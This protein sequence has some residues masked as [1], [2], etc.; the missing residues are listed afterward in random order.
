MS[1]VDIG[2]LSCST[3]TLESG[4]IHVAQTQLT[5]GGF[6]SGAGPLTI[7]AHGASRIFRGDNASRFFDIAGVVLE[8]GLV[9]DDSANGRA[10]GGCVDVQGE[11][12]LDQ[13]T[14]Q[15]C[16]VHVPNGKAL[17]GAVYASYFAHLMFSTVRNSEAIGFDAV[18]GGVYASGEVFEA[19]DSTVE[20]N[21]ATATGTGQLAY[22]RGRNL[23]TG[24]RRDGRGNGVIQPEHRRR[25]QC[26]RRWHRRQ[27]RIRLPLL[28][29]A[30]GEDHDYWQRRA[31]ARKQR[32]G[33]RRAR[34]RLSLRQ[35]RG[36]Q[37]VH[38]QRGR[39]HRRQ[40]RH[41]HADRLYRA[42]HVYG[43]P[44]HRWIVSALCI[45]RC[46][47][48]ELDH[49][50]NEAAGSSAGLYIYGGTPL[51]IESTIAS[52]NVSSTYDSAF[53]LVSGG[54]VTGDHNLIVT[55]SA[56]LP[57]DTLHADPQL[58][59]LANNGGYTMT[60]GLSASSAAIDVGS[61][62]T[63]SPCD[64]RGF[65]FPRLFGNGIDIGAYELNGLGRIFGNG[66]DP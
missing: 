40:R 21:T 65:G 5:I 60:L 66:F 34:Q 19:E 43:Q 38:Q 31:F 44:L 42:E 11:V 6:G 9:Q 16:A 36:E 47:R 59:P 26:R 33:L 32:R 29:L 58:L 22:A 18:G 49:R 23:R 56:A 39:R 41:A 24:H 28:R 45:D 25:R 57:P 52:N 46:P 54:P 51:D 17:G 37:H 50:L 62:P 63:R 4:E 14:L 10:H 3:I 35:P 1:S 53:D 64:Q 48:V 20:G 13:V 12:E 15:N 7:D 8:N 2:Q 27:R 55:S 30:S 61:D